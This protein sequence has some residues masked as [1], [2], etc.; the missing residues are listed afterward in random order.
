M[1]RKNLLISPVGKKA[2]EISQGWSLGDRSYDILLIYY[3]DEGHEDFMRISDYLILKKGFKYP[4]LHEILNDI[5]IF[6]SKYDYFFLPDDDVRMTSEDI[7]KLFFF[8]EIQQTVICQPSLYPKNFTWPITQHNPDTI[9]RYVSMVEIMCP[10]F[11]RDALLKC[12][13][14]FV[15][16]QSGWGLEV[17]WYRLL[18]SQEYQFIIYDM[19][20]AIH[21]GV[22]GDADS[23]MY[24]NLTK[25]GIDP[26]DE[27]YA[28]EKKYDWRINFYDV[29]HV[30]KEVID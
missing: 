15:E 8:A 7:N 19:V 6:L 3:D 28:L 24:N 16:S 27:Y 4:L 21:E 1:E 23:K 9:F 10:L 2:F 11:S 14:S 5:Q 30:Y 12:L 26:Q 20:I 29:A 18:G 13:P 17:A 22:R 25:I